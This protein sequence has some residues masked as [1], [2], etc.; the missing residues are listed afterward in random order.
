M[1]ACGV[2]HLEGESPESEHVCLQQETMEEEEKGEGVQFD[3]LPFEIGLEK[4]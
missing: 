1:P 3:G 2:F 4:T